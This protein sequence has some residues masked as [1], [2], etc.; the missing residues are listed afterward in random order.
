V[1]ARLADLDLAPRRAPAELEIVRIEDARS[2]A[3]ALDDP[4]HARL[5]ASLGIEDWAPV[6][7]YGATRQA[8]RGSGEHADR[9]RDR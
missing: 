7:H 3:K 5:L 6:R 2:L 1:A 8:H 9:R 4:A